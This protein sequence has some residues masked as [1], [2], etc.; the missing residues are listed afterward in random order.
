[1]IRHFQRQGPCRKTVDLTTRHGGAGPLTFLHQGFPLTAQY[2]H[3]AKSGVLDIS[4]HH[5][6]M[7]SFAVSELLEPITAGGPGHSKCGNIA[8]AA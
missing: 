7:M 8:K 5:L 3:D 4:R 2:W 6:D 1:M